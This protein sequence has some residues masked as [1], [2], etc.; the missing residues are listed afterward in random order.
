MQPDGK[1]FIDDVAA[2]DLWYFP[3]GYPHSLQGIGPDGTDF[4]LVFNDGSFSEEDTFL[5]S[6][7]LVHT[8]PEV[9]QKNM[10]WNLES[11][12]KLPAT[13]LYIF[14]NTLPPSLQDQQR[15]LGDRRETATQYTYKLSQQEPDVVR[16]GGSLKLIDVTRFPVANKICAGLVTLKPGGMREMHWHTDSDEWQYYIQGKGR[17]TIASTGARARTMDFNANDIGIV[18]LMATH[19]IENIGTEDLVFLEML[20]SSHFIDVSI[21]E[22]IGALP[23]DVAVAHLKLPLSIIRSGPQTK[24]DILPK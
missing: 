13:Q 17:M 19:Y 9:I 11:F 18:P 15:A 24:L 5:I 16:T 2:G 10:G 8:P 20:R 22:W 3:A 12:N 7:S 14:P 4:L 6:E 23:D 1:M 21:N